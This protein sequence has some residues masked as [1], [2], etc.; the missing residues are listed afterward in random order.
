MSLTRFLDI[1]NPPEIGLLT[2]TQ[3]IHMLNWQPA[4]LASCF[5]VNIG[6]GNLT[7]KITEHILLFGTNFEKVC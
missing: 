7:N 6:C 3:S 5:L 1:H 4:C 2:K